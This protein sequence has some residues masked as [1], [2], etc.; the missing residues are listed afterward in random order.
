MIWLKTILDWFYIEY[1]TSFITYDLEL[2][3]YISIDLL[4]A[5]FKVLQ[6]EYEVCNNPIDIEFDD[7]TMKTKL[8]V[9]SRI[10][11]IRFDEKSFF[12]TIL[13]FI[14][15]WDYK[16]CNEY[17]SRKVLKLSTINKIHLKTNII[18][19]SVVNGIRQPTLVSFVLDKPAGYK[20]F[21]E[22]ETIH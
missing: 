3:S 20:I 16:Q 4:E 6:P 15:H 21:C 17:V 9:R 13:G 14:S 22:P 12:S 19:G 2:G 5:P 7:T 11:A 18:D 1:K 10:K 8:I